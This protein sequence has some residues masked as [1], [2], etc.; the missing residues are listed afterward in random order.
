[1]SS[2]VVTCS[3][4]AER[5]ECSTR[6]IMR[7]IEK[8]SMAGVPVYMNRGKGGGVGIL[9]DYIM[10]KTM[11]SDAEKKQILSSMQAMKETAF[12]TE[13]ETLEKLRSIFG[14]EEDDW[15]EIEFSRWGTPGKIE[16]Y[17]GKI[18]KAILEN[19]VLCINYAATEKDPEQ[20]E[21]QPLKLCYRCNSWYM[22]A[23]CNLRNDYRFFKLSRILDLKFTPK[24]FKRKKIGRVLNLVYSPMEKAVQIKLLVKKDALYRAVEELPVAQILDDGNAVCVFECDDLQATINYVLSYGPHAEVLEPEFVKEKVRNAIESMAGIY[25][26][27]KNSMQ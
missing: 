21:V 4:L 12:G 19:S 24:K 15:L 11:F 27:N 5:F 23:Y 3:Q 25:G 10:D 22:Y 16:E 1:M 8:L 26:V 18:K 7:D 14:R 17:F 13:K 6:T 20:R 2:D 9:P